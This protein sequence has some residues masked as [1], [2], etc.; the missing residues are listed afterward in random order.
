MNQAADPA[1]F[2]RADALV[3]H[4]RLIRLAERTWLRSMAI[5]RG[6]RAVV[7]MRRRAEAFE[8]LSTSAQGQC[9]FVVAAT[10]V[11]GHVLAARV[12]PSAARPDVGLTALVLIA[13]FIAAVAAAVRR[14]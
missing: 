7:A 3:A 12:L 5:A 4:S 6:S 2:Q 13:L 10:A 8:R 11:L 1:S 9:V 14:R